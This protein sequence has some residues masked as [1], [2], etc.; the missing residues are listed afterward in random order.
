MQHNVSAQ[1]MFSKDRL[2]H[3]LRHLRQQID[4]IEGTVTYRA[5]KAAR[6]TDMALHAHPYTAMGLAGLAGLL[7]GALLARR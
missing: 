4:D 1:D 2:A 3:D 6:A 5:R 7:I